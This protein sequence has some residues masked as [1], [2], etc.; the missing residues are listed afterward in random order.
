MIKEI[1]GVKYVPVDLA[2]QLASPKGFRKI[3]ESKMSQSKTYLKAYEETEELHVC[4]FQIRKYSCY[5]SFAT[6]NKT[7]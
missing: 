5:Q 6:S 4:V 3:F 2:A 1:E 7:K